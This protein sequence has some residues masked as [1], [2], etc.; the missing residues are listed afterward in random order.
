MVPGDKDK[1]WTQINLG[2]NS[3]DKQPVFASRFSQA[4]PSCGEET[5]APILYYRASPVPSDLHTDAKSVD[6]HAPETWMDAD[7]NTNVDSWEIYHYED[8]YSI[9]D[10]GR[11]ATKPVT[12]DIRYT[13][14][15]YAPSDGLDEKG[16]PF[17]DQDPQTPSPAPRVWGITQPYPKNTAASALRPT[18]EKPPLPEVP[19]NADSFILISPGPDGIYFTADD[20]TNYR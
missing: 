6:T 20:V 3:S 15:L 16:K 10:P 4:N 19:Y 5:G 12:P 13:H 2:T 1:T 8:N 7:K 14:R 17:V 9:T 11:Y 18:S